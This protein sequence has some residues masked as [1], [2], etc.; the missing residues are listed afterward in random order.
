MDAE[1]RSYISFSLSVWQKSVFQSRTSLLLEKK[2][3]LAKFLPDLTRIVFQFI[4]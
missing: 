3:T 4:L 1:I 2:Y